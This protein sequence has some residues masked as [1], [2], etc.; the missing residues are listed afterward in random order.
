VRIVT[1]H[2]PVYLPWL[3][4]L[5][6]ASLADV[7]IYMDDVQYLSQDWNNRN[8]IKTA[9]GGAS[10][11][12]VPIDK[13]GSDFTQIRNVCID[14]QTN[15]KQN[16]QDQHWK[17]L[18]MAYGKAPFFNKYKDFFDWLYCAQN[19]CSL[20]EL[21]L[22]LL[23]QL[24]KWFAIKASIVIASEEQFTG[25]KEKLV[26]EHGKRF[27]ADIVVTGTLGCDYITPEHFEEEGMQ[28]YFQ[29]YQ[30]PTYDQRFGPFISH[31]SCI[32]LLFNHGE[33]SRDICLS[34]N[35]T[36]EEL[37]QRVAEKQIA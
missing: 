30:H 13:K 5:H 37:C 20:S 9:Q 32:D 19:W 2:Q 34:K 10:W 4:L 23:N 1:G 12:T 31:L 15:K 28:V 29:D 18:C 6:K 7:F 27:H 33:E 14:R 17:S 26:I 16:W 24:F 8:K 22:V 25:K 36:R 3:G 21:N 11:L 35:I